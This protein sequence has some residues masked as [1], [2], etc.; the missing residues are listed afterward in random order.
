MEG[1]IYIY[2]EI[3]KPN[4]FKDL[5]HKIYD[6]LEDL[7]FAIIQK[8]PEKHIPSSFMKWMERYTNKRLSELQSQIIRKRWQTIE[9]EKAVDKIHNKQQD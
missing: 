3:T 4:R 8:I 7:T 9:L 6:H 1:V 2:I 5:L